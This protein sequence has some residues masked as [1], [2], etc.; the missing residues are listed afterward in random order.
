MTDAVKE[1]A[2]ALFAIALEKDALPSF[3]QNLETVAGVVE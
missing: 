3:A 2:E 1:Y